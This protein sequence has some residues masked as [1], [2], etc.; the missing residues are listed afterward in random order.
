MITHFDM[1]TGETIDD[2]VVESTRPTAP[3]T[4]CHAPLRLMTVAEAAAL[5]RAQRQPMSGLLDI[6][7]ERLLHGARREPR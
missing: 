4:P 2:P 5:E 7:V 6:P 3:S 1:L